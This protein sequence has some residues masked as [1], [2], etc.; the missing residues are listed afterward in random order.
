LGRDPEPEVARRSTAAAAPELSLGDERAPAF[1]PPSAPFH[2]APVAIY[3][4]DLDGIV[5]SWNRAAEALFGWCADEVIGKPV[6]FI[7]RDEIAKTVEAR[8]RLMDGESIS[9]VEYCPV[10]RDG[11]AKHVVTSASMLR[12]ESGRAT[13]VIGF[14]VDVTETRLADEAVARAEAKWRLLLQST[15]DTVTL[16]DAD[17]RVRQTTG[18]FSDIL[19]YEYDWWPGRSGFDLIHP[20]D[21]PRAAGVFAELVD[22]PG[23]TYAEVLRTR[24]A[25]GHWEL[26]EYTAVNRLDDP[27]VESIVITTRNVTDFTQAEAMLADEAKILELIARGAPLQQTLEAIAGMVDYHTGGDSGVFLLD[28]NRSRITSC[29]APA[30]P[31]ELVVAARKAVLTPGDEPIIGRSEPA[32]CGDFRTRAGAS[33]ADFLV[34]L[35]YL[36]GWSVPVIDT[37]DGG[38]VGTIGVLYVSPRLPANRERD[39]VGVASH[40]AAI[41]I[42]SDRTQRDLEHQ[43]RHDQ[44]TGLPNRWAIVERLDEAIVR[45]RGSGSSTAV[46]L[47]DLDRFKVVNDSLGHGAGD[48]LLVAFGERLRGVI[49]DTAFV[50]HF[51][52]DEF[53]VILDRVDDLDQVLHVASRIDLA[54]SEPFTIQTALAGSEYE[55][56]LSTSIGVALATNGD[57][58]HEV[59]QH[60]DAAM[61]RAKDRGRDRL[62]VFDE[63]MKTRAT[64]L[65]RVDRDLRLAVER[66]ELSLHYQPKVDLNTGRIIGAEAL[67]RWSHPERGIV[68]PSEFIGVAEETGLI[69]RI[70]AWVLEEAVRQARAWTDRLDLER[71]AIA[72]N[73]S[74][75]Q[76]SAPGLV[77]AVARV[78]VRYDWPAEQLTLELTESIL[79]DDG[80][81]AI[82]VLDELK[83]LG[84]RLA[85]DDFGTG[86]SSL[87]YLHRFPVDVVKVD[88]AF[89]TPLTA[90][91]EGSPVAT[92][93]MHMARALGLI[94]SAEGVEDEHQL[95][96]LRSLGCDW[97]QGFLFAEALPA[98]QMA[99]LLASRPHW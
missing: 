79:I 19:G 9:A 86:Y 21:L 73:I 62:E 90:D 29:A 36:A 95:A 64:E 25:R 83:Q 5:L 97:A 20:D 69:V 77:A 32:E 82:G 80:G 11:T 58:A 88:R 40:L 53:V 2:D 16:V 3:T 75:R 96:G 70:G 10:T 1:G 57:S 85:I 47:L 87:S 31:H 17:G 45:V 71:L 43:A 33:D 38:V 46:L 49:G 35:G 13:S 26:V 99:E 92:A 60:A 42:E 8:S 48:D 65:L 41:A 37:R 59:L 34:D 39:T 66:A 55:L 30:M 89:V 6:P 68:L 56:H 44:L 61:Y 81:A 72:V 7:P 14:A 12:D 50:G 51:G 93:V 76:L 63:E 18:E 67:L 28:A 52:G 98:D 23:E 84:V 22:H 94:A 74:A 24:H 78:L 27:L 15:S 91:G 54:L 4:I